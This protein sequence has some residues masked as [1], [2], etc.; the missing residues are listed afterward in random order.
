MTLEQLVLWIVVGG[1]AGFLADAVVSGTRLGVLE[2]IVVGIL[3]AFVGGWLFAQLGA[4][5]GG[6]LLGQILTAFVGAVILL[7]ILVAASRR[8]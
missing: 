7:V 6:G 4:F 3:G 1:I 5:P 2:S 8:T